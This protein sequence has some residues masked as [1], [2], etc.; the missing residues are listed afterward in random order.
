[1]NNAENIQIKFVIVALVVGA[2]VVIFVD[3]AYAEFAS[4]N[5][6]WKEKSPAL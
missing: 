2:P 6:H 4:A 3:L 1:V 5:L